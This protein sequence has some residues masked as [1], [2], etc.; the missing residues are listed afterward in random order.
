MCLQKA[1][2][3]LTLGEMKDRLSRTLIGGNE[4]QSRTLIGEMK[5]CLVGLSLGEIKDRLVGLSLGE[6]K[7]CL[8]RT[9]QIV[10]LKSE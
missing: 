8:S 10:L 2:G 9:L 6:M 3:G 4:R 5:D 1:F 7:D